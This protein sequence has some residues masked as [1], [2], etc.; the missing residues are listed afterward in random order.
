MALVFKESAIFCRKLAQVA[1]NCDHNIDAGFSTSFKSRGKSLK[2][3][4]TNFFH[5]LTNVFRYLEGCRFH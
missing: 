2:S 1:E 5:F 4:A 3:P